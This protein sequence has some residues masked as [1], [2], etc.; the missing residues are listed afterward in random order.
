MI[1]YLGLGVQAVVL[2]V[3]D[4]RPEGV[5]IQEHIQVESQAGTQ[6]EIQIAFQ[7][8]AEL[9]VGALVQKEVLDSLPV[10]ASDNLHCFY[11]F[12]QVDHNLE[13]EGSLGYMEFA[14]A[15]C[16]LKKIIIGIIQVFNKLLEL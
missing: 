15:T 7:V 9:Q 8:R 1:V 6:V 14:C 5:G 16:F 3:L 4:N 13:F 11:S 10:V 2:L 12:L